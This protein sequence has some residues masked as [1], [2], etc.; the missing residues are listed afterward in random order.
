MSSVDPQTHPVES[1]ATLSPIPDVLPNDTEVR[2]ARSLQSSKV[3]SSRL[4]R[5]FHYG[6]N[7]V[8]Y[9]SCSELPAYLRFR[10]GCFFRL[11][12]GLRIAETVHTSDRA[13]VN[14]AHDDRIQY[15]TFGLQIDADAWR[16]SEARPVHEHTRYSKIITDRAKFCGR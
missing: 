2:P 11:W 10:P 8:V 14:I 1:A 9:F 6:G 13:R 3:P 16:S 12:C 7:T 4:G 5:L 15:Q